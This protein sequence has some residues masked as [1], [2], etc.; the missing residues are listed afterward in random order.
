VPREYLAISTTWTQRLPPWSL[1][2]GL[3]LQLLQQPFLHQQRTDNNGLR[4]DEIQKPH[5]AEAK[6]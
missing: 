4:V 1:Q 3:S 5:N 6:Q 2:Y